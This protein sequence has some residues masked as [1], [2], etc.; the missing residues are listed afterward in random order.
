MDKR[1]NGNYKNHWLIAYDIRSNSQRTQLHRFLKQVALS[2][3]KSFFEIRAT[4]NRVQYK[5]HCCAHP[6]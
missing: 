6:A 3:Q 2:Y 5:L 1:S 4:E